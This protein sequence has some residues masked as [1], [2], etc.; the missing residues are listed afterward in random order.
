MYLAGL[1]GLSFFLQLIVRF[2]TSILISLEERGV[3]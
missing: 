3:S 2:G 1:V